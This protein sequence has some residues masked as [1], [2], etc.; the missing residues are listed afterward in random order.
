MKPIEALLIYNIDF[1]DLNR[2]VSAGE[3]WQYSSKQ[4]GG[5]KQAMIQNKNS[6]QFI[7]AGLFEYNTQ[8]EYTHF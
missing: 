8:F 7:S 6:A 3:L 4:R 1:S 2:M 5:I